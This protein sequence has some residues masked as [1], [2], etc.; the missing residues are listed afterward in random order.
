MK[1][2]HLGKKQGDK[3][4]FHLLKLQKLG[5]SQD[6]FL[7]RHWYQWLP[8][9]SGP[10]GW[11]VGVSWRSE[12]RVIFS[13]SL[14]YCPELCWPIWQPLD[15]QGCCAYKNVANPNGDVSE[16]QIHKMFFVCLFLR[17]TLTVI[18]AGVPLGMILVH[19]SLHL[20]GSNDWSRTPDL[21]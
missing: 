18:H 10:E 17:C 13:V 11:Q 7:K 9:G 2:F 19:H 20:L 16:C 6:I 8:L 21:R 1:C 15:M 3:I 14:L 5:G 12:Q 4:V